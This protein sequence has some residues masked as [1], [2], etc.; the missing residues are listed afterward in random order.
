M[1]IE[2]N[3]DGSMKE[4]AH[5]EATMRHIDLVAANLGKFGADL[6]VRATVHDDSKFTK[7]E[8]EALDAM[9]RLVEIEGP[10]DYGSEEYD[11]RK[12]IMA[13]MLNHHYANNDHHPEHH[14]RGIDDMNLMQIV[15]MLCDWNA[16]N[17][18]RDGGKPMGLS[19]SIERYGIEPQ[20]ADILKNTCDAMGFAWE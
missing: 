8:S 2:F 6:A 4:Y 14:A 15:E 5:T 3:E 11:R 7:I 12:A 19:K 20:L 13:P 9:K 17:V 16:S 1:T 10:A 18:E